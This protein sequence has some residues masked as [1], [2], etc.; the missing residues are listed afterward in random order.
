KVS[1]VG[2][3]R[4]PFWVMEKRVRLVPVGSSLLSLHPLKAPGPTAHAR[5]SHQGHS[6]YAPGNTLQPGA[7]GRMPEQFLSVGLYPRQLG[8]GCNLH[9]NHFSCNFR[10]AVAMRCRSNVR[11]LASTSLS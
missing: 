1:L 9:R 3:W 10:I 5:T 6:F 7:N 8:T 2:H 4:R 11:S